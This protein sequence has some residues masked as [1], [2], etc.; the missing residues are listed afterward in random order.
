M[1][2]A[3]LLILGGGCAGLSLG[4]RLA[5]QP[6][7]GRTMIL[8]ARH[9]YAN[10]RTWCFWRLQP[11]RFQHLVSCS[12]SSMA[13]TS[14]ARRVTFDCTS[15][16]YEMIPANCFYADAQ[17]VFGRSSQVRLSTGA[18]VLAPPRL[19]AGLWRVE[20]TGGP[21][22]A[23][24]IVDTRPVRHDYAGELPL[25]QSF[26][27]EEI[28]CET[29]RFDP[30]KAELM[31]FDDTRREDVL[32]SYVLPSSPTR[33]LVETTVFG[34]KQLGAADLAGIQA[35]AVQRFCGGARSQVVRTERGIL[36]MT[37]TKRPAAT[38]GY[39][40][41]GLM[42]GAARP[43]TGYA[44]QRIQRWADLCAH[45]IA[46]GGP[47]IGHATEPILRREMDRLFLRVLRNHPDRGPELFTRMFGNGEPGR[48]IRFLSDAGTLADCISLGFRL[49]IGLFIGELA[50]SLVQAPVRGLPQEA[51][52]DLGRHAA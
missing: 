42:S 5:E 24:R 15:T 21:V 37:V 46:T 4:L 2:D 43:S 34:P 17:A 8:E 36:P 3:D 30:A 13:I 9:H 52:L 32:F 39:V 18:T 41:V 20:T 47:A 40:R 10:D 16:P 22:V 12:W 28:E 11:H 19:V 48:V 1:V 7:S 25:W 49:P 38:P 45:S 50:R 35:D 44:F 51:S 27:G 33:A 26:I 14:A 29:G 31:Q 23:R 6:H